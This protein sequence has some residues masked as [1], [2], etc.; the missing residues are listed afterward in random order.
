[1][2]KSCKVVEF[3]RCVSTIEFNPSMDLVEIRK[4]HYGDDGEVL[5]TS[6]VP[7]SL[8]SNTFETAMQ[9]ASAIASN[10]GLVEYVEK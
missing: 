3:A 8:R 5:A 6:F 10:V 1:M 7:I 2:A 9:I 4:L